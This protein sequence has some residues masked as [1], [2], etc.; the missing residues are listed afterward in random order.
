MK[1]VRLA[2]AALLAI[3]AFAANAGIKYWDNPAYK[4]FDVGDYVS[5]AVWNYDG[6]RNIGANADHDPAALTW[7]NLGSAGAN[8]NV[9]LQKA[10]ANWPNASAEELASGTY[11]EWTEKGFVFKGTSRMRCETG[12]IDAGTS[13]SLQF[14]LDAQSS[15]QQEGDGGFVLSVSSAYFALCINKADGKLYWRTRMADNDRWP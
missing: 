13:Y 8:N 10:V 15:A 7:V 9:V 14:L 4:A 1:G 2:A 11:G 12:R 3:F 6:I 5:G